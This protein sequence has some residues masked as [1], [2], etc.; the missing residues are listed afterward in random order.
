MDKTIEGYLLELKAALAGCDPALIQDA[1]YDAEEYLRDAV[2]EGGEDP[3]A[4]FEAAMADYGTPEEIAAAY[5]D[6]ELT[7]A[8][9]LKTPRSSATKSVN[10]LVR[11]FGVVADPLAWGSLFYML[12]SLATGIIYFT[13]IVTGWSLTLGTVVLIIGL[14]IAL[15]MLAVVRAISLAEGRLVEG[16]LG[17]R[18]PR[19]PRA[20]GI[21]GDNIWGRIMSW[22]KD[23]RTWTSMLYML[24]QLPLGIL[25]FTVVV[26][27]I[28]ISAGLILWP[29]A[30]AMMNYPMFQTIGYAYYVRPWAI[31]L[32]MAMGAMGLVLTLWVTRGVGMLHGWYAKTLLV[33]RVEKG[34]VPEAAPGAASGAA[35]E[36]APGAASEVAPE[37]MEG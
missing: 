36:V 24:L 13:V 37:T 20:T 16:L 1:M 26:T 34:S 35:S 11:F 31:P 14:P 19:R 22:L 15:L 3:E 8:A 21:K 10:P 30:A 6:A 28:S 27:A 5:R 12:L 23:V 9:A 33:G 4:A 17:V 29:F 25:Y 7:V 2:A 18:M 32:I